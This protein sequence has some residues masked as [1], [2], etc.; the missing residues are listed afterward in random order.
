M[1]EDEKSPERRIRESKAEGCVCPECGKNVQPEDIAK[2]IHDSIAEI[3]WY[4][5]C[6]DCGIYCN[7]VDNSHWYPDE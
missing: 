5:G 6:L 2:K 7:A 3:H 1:T 4:P